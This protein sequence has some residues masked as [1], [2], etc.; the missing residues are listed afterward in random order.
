[1]SDIA[2]CL[3]RTFS[4]L[5]NYSKMCLRN[6]FW[7]EI[8]FPRSLCYMYVAVQLPS[9]VRLFATPWTAAHQ[10]SLSLTI[11]QSLPSSCLLHRCMYD[12]VTN[13]SLLTEQKQEQ[14]EQLLF[15]LLQGN[16]WPKASVLF[17]SLLFGVVANSDFGSWAPKMAE[18]LPAWNRAAN[19]PGG[20]IW[21]VTQEKNKLL[22]GFSHWIWDVSEQFRKLQVFYGSTSTIYVYP[23]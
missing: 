12:H 15:D 2:K 23:I 8:A 16:L 19:T 1:M 17:F 21:T 10:A 7:L 22:S 3:L 9:H 18:A 13:P 5:L 14:Y 4:L 11:S 6:G 20:A